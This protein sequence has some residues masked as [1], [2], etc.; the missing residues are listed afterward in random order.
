VEEAAELLRLGELVAFPTETVYGLGADAGNPLAV[1]R[2]YAL[3]GRPMGH[4]LIVHIHSIEQAG[5]WC[6]LSAEA[7]ALAELYW[8]G[9]L[10]LI[11]PRRKGVPDEVTGGLETVGI[12]LPSHPQ[13]RRLLKTFGGGIA[14]PSAN[15]FGGISPT[16]PGHV[17]KDFG[18]GLHILDGGTCEIGIESTIV[19]LVHGPAVLRPGQISKAQLEQC[20]GPLKKASSTAAPGTLKGHY[21]PRTS[22]HLTDRPLEDAE[23]F[24]SEGLSV[25]VLLAPAP[26]EYAQILYR[27]L[28][29][30]DER[31]V[32]ILVAERCDPD[33]IGIA[34]NDRLQRASIGSKLELKHGES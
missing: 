25:E 7:L 10:T 2:V 24:R 9:P 21:S 18:P 16:S 3:K 6:R 26:G 28:R 11:L 20:I 19:D 32:D 23:S 30:M 17:R 29:N 4:P 14:A 13:A 34:V 27:E 15:R 5:R 1:R 12:R 31:G 22:L 33:G 8:P